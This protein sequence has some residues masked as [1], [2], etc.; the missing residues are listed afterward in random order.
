MRASTEPGRLHI[1]SDK[2]AALLAVH[3]FGPVLGPLHSMDAELV[4]EAHSFAGM[5]A[6]H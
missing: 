1:W 6:W 4:L 2:V 5:A 3:R